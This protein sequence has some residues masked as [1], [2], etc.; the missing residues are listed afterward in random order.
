M[1][2]PEK[3]LSDGIVRLEEKMHR[4]GWDEPD[5]LFAMIGTTAG[6]VPEFMRQ[7]F[8]RQTQA[9]VAYDLTGVL[10]ALNGT[11]LNELADAMEQD[12]DA[13]MIAGLAKPEFV[14]FAVS[15]ET[16]VNMTMTPEERAEDPRRLADIPGSVEARQIVSVDVAGRALMVH[17]QRGKQPITSVS[18][19]QGRSLRGLARMTWAVARKM[20]LGSVELDALRDLVAAQRAGSSVDAFRTRMRRHLHE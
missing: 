9:L 18:E 14:G 15:V 17:R 20:P 10:K 6:T 19:L 3:V 11:V 1:I 5:K 8:P 12:P 13:G 16:W 7:G 4:G 2:V